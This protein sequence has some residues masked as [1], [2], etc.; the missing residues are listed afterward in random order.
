MED[1]A[2]FKLGLKE[3]ALFPRLSKP[4]A[5]SLPSLLEPSEANRDSSDIPPKELLLNEPELLINIPI[6]DW[7]RRFCR[8]LSKWTGDPS[9]G[10]M[11]ARFLARF[12]RLCM[13]RDDRPWLLR[14]CFPKRES[15]SLVP[16]LALSLS[17]AILD[18]NEGALGGGLG[19]IGDFVV[20]DVELGSDF[21]SL[22]GV[23][24]KGSL[25]IFPYIEYGLELGGGEL[26]LEARLNSVVF[27]FCMRGINIVELIEEVSSH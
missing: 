19:D 18:I 14:R 13:A 23:S 25:H 26:E 12:D 3:V 22:G 21:L 5:V 2:R 9:R 20:W 11:A 17:S 24:I 1:K 7:S 10:V 4:V 27:D 16:N 8:P 15:T 6:S